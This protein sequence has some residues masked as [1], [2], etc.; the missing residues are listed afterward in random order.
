MKLAR[1]LVASLEKALPPGGGPHRLSIKLGDQWLLSREGPDPVADLEALDEQSPDAECRIETAGPDG[2][3]AT[4]VPYFRLRPLAARDPIVVHG[5]AD[6]NGLPVRIMVYDEEAREYVLDYACFDRDFEVDIADVPAGRLMRTRFYL[7]SPERNSWVPTGHSRR[8]EGTGKVGRP[9]VGAE[10][11]A[12]A[13]QLFE[14]VSE[15]LPPQERSPGALLEFYDDA[16]FLA[17]APAEPAGEGDL[18]QTLGQLCATTSTFALRV[19]TVTLRPDGAKDVSPLLNLSSLD[20]AVEAMKAYLKGDESAR[21]AATELLA[22]R[23]RDDGPA[24]RSTISTLLFKTLPEGIGYSPKQWPATPISA[25]CAAWDSLPDGSILVGEALNYI[26]LYDALGKEV[27]RRNLLDQ[28]YLVAGHLHDC[29]EP[30]MAVIDSLPERR[31]QFYGTRMF[32]GKL[33]SLRDRDAAAGIFAATLTEQTLFKQ[34]CTFDGGGGTYFSEARIRAN[35]PALVARQDELAR[36]LKTLS[37]PE[38]GRCEPVWLFSCDVRFL[39]IYM[40]HWLATAEYCKRRN[41]EFHF[42]V[43][44]SSEETDKAL[45]TV[46]ALRR[47]LAELRGFDP[48]TYDSNI[49]FS[50]WS[51]PDWCPEPITIYA[52]ARYLAI[53]ELSARFDRSILIQDMDFTLVEDPEAF[54]S[55]F[56]GPGFG[57]QPSR[58][59]YGL[60]AWRRFMGGT[61]FAP[62]SDAARR[63]LKMLEAYL[64]EGLPIG[65]SWYLDQNALAFFFE[66]TSRSGESGFWSLIF[67]RP[68]EQPRVNQ[69]FEAAQP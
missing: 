23:Q 41:V 2:A 20:G 46:E 69:L 17:D 68:T 62:N 31:K 27:V 44:G 60:D 58:G 34:A 33:E 13:N 18:R 30:V 39:A 8:L 40:P 26:R 67:H 61:F 28:N 37:R 35:L 16:V 42:I 56:P 3:F 6:P 48:A 15:L 24:L 64:L 63:D 19:R 12:R 43:I 49:S 45:A 51:S 65:R 7:W 25:L 66:R 11:Q 21:E 38:P 54:M 29:I 10:D 22:L 57:I 36:S 53:G 14:R 59:M 5:P 9:L 50:T 55:R 32:R 52:C 4:S 47:N 1:E